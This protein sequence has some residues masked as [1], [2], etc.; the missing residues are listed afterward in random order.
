MSGDRMTQADFHRRYQH[1]PDDAKFELVGGIV[2]MASPTRIAH[3]EHG[4]TLGTVLGLYAISTPGV[5]AS[6]DA[7]CILGEESEPQ[8]DHLLRILRECGGRSWVDDDEYLRG[9]PEWVGEIAY[10]SRAIDLNQKKDDYQRAGV[11]EYLVHSLEDRTLHWFDFVAHN[12]IRPSRDGVLRSRV[13]PGLWIH[14]E[15]LLSRNGTRLVEVLN[16]GLA[17]RAH[18]VFV[19]RLAR[20]RKQFDRTKG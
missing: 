11:C 14:E 9:P 7:T 8:P 2:Y 10:S 6:G 18:A 3:G 16:K 15:A 12:R 17:S 19:R 20:A 13:F 1:Y 5:V 4:A